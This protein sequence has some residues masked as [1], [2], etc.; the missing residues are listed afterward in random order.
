[1]RHTKALFLIAICV[2]VF[3]TLSFFDSKE[4]GSSDE[5]EQFF[6]KKTT[7]R[8]QSN[9]KFSAFQNFLNDFVNEHDI[10]T[11]AYLH[12]NSTTKKPRYQVQHYL[13]EALIENKQKRISSREFE[14]ISTSNIPLSLEKTDLLI[15]HDVLQHVPP[16]EILLLLKQFKR[17]K[18]CLLSF[19]EQSDPNKPLLDLAKPPYNL[20]AQKIFTFKRDDS[21]RTVQV[22]Y[23]ENN[24]WDTAEFIWNLGIASSCDV[25]PDGDPFKLFKTY[26]RVRWH[27]NVDDYADIKAGDIVWLRVDLVTPFYKQVLPNIKEP[28]VLV[29]NNGDESFPS[30]FAHEIDVESFIA[31]D[32]IIH[33][34]AQNCNYKGSSTK[35]TSIPIG[36]D[37]HSIAYKGGYW[38]ETGSVKQQQKVLK[39]ILQGLQPTY[40]RKPKAFVDFQHN[41]IRWGDPK[42]YSEHGEDR[43]TIFK[44]LLPTQLI[45]FSGRIK[46]SDLWKTKGQ[47][48][49]S[50]SPHGIGLDCHRTWE[51][52]LLGCIVIVK[53]SALDKLYEG[54]P[55]V[56]VNDW[57]EVTRENMD[58]WLKQ[59]GDAFTN[60]SYRE[61]LT[62]AY[63]INQIKEKAAPYKRKR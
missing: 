54:L 9:L 14:L 17:F 38:G 29:I 33:I 59:Y 40:L 25:M 2:I 37:F 61:K 60:P 3:L 12:L 47:Y 19:E 43:A 16:E 20:N 39:D 1:M 34:F 51:D 15:C 10:D 45:E 49:F 31:N 44:R 26:D 7:G 27:I 11:V 13:L 63:W 32:K 57:F 22:Y 42:R 46:R 53:T 8:Q 55:V 56:I 30:E 23:I 62:N 58:K 18:H 41:V 28:F 35:V 21:K 24:T 4:K 36:M 6:Q 52:L 5:L 50:V 48:A